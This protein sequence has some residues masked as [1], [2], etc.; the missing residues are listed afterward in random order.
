MKKSSLVLLVLAAMSASVSFADDTTPSMDSAQARAQ[1]FQSLTP[2]QQQAAINAAKQQGQATAQQKQENW[3]SM[4]PEQQ[5]AQKQT[6]QSNMQSKM[7]E[8]KSKMQ[9]RMGSGGGGMMRSRMGM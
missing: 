8:M 4:T 5:Q 7:G 1:T 2:E 6:M 3:N 9:S